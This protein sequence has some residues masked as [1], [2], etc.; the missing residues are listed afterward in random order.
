MAKRVF[1]HYFRRVSGAIENSP[2]QL[3]QEFYSR[4][5]IS[6]DV[7]KH[8][9]T[10]RGLSSSQKSS[11][12]VCAV[13]TTIDTASNEKPFKSFCQAMKSFREL[14]NLAT[15]MTEKFGKCIALHNIGSQGKAIYTNLILCCLGP[16]DPNFGRCHSIM[17]VWVDPSPH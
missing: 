11:S 14:E 17:I 7:M 8:V 15:K 3:A 2:D 12:L 6:Q 16:T 1:Q 5:L 10:T 9:L 13:L 4:T